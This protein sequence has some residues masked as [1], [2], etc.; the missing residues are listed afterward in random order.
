MR[1][2]GAEVD[3]ALTAIS[4]ALVIRTARDNEATND[5]AADTCKR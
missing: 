2:R 4:I 1:R 3:S 5:S